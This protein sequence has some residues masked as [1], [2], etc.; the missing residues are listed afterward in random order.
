MN[1]S[2]GLGLLP[3]LG[4]IFVVLKLTR[5]IDW[6]WLWVLSPFWI[7][8]AVAVILFVVIIIKMPE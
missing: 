2:K 1:K 4:L 8:V 6:S 3:I 5:I 7:D